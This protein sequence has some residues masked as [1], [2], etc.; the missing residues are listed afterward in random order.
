MVH[1]VSSVVASRLEDLAKKRGW[2]RVLLCLYSLQRRWESKASNKAAYSSSV[3]R[4]SH[5]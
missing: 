1:Y 5:P 4:Q 3:Q 2:K